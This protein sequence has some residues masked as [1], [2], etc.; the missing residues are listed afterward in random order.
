MAI[1]I[2]CRSMLLSDMLQ[3]V[4]KDNDFE[5]R[6]TC[7]KI[8][9][10]SLVQDRDIVL[11]YFSENCKDM[12][13]AVSGLRSSNQSPRI[14]ILC[15]NSIVDQLREELGDTVEA[16]IPDTLHIDIL[17]VALNLIMNGYKILHTDQLRHDHNGE[18]PAHEVH[19]QHQIV[20]SHN[21]ILSKRETAILASLLGG[22]PNKTIG[23]KLG[24]SEATVKV[25]LR[26]IY[27]KAGVKNRTQAALWGAEHLL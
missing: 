24:I 27:R 7:T 15:A 3:S 17:T 13:N 16:I 8:S 21:D 5:I 20:P 14:L 10:L 9:E 2:V 22:L 4:C 25:H 12:A 23:K 26:A 1:S 18:P 11:I 6:E 19:S